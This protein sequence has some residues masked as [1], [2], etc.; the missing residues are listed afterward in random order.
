MPAQGARHAKRT[1]MQRLKEHLDMNLPFLK[2]KRLLLAVSGGVDSMVMAEAFIR[3]G[4]DVSLA[5][6]NFSLRGKE[7][8]GDE[9]FVRNYAYSNGIQ[10]FFQR[11]DTKSFAADNRLSP[12]LAARQLRYLWFDELL[13]QGFDYLLT[14]HHADDNLET[15]FINLSRRSG[16]SGLT[17]IPEQNGKIVR[18]L[19]PFSRE[20]LLV[21]WREDSSNASMD[22]LRNKIRHRL[23]PALK[24]TLPDFPDA[25]ARSMDHLSMA[26][27]LTDDAAHLVYKEVAVELPEKTLLRIPELT[28]LEHYPAYLYHWLS[29]YGFTAWDDIYSL[30]HAQSGKMVLSDSHRLVKDREVLILEKLKGSDDAQVIIDSETTQIQRPVSLVLSPVDTLG[31]PSDNRIFADA[32][33]LRFPLVLRKWR[34][35]DTFKPFGMEGTKKVSKF[36]KDEKLALPDKEAQWLLC[37]GDDIVWIIGRRMDDRFKVTSDTRRIISIE[38]LP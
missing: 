36:F 28:R 7:S 31:D 35:G 23:I 22:Y 12:Q 6:C 15:F 25:I 1:G 26:K 38:Y 30:P 10:A 19:L 8:D 16:I 34:E 29:P 27:R 32:E 9:K 37:S 14:A 18:P 21:E 20:E 24:E 2:G 4:Y 3:L 13:E 33:S 17:G 11:F 5:H